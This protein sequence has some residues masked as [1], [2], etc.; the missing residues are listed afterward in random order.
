MAAAAESGLQA[1]LMAPTELL[2][3]QHY[4]SLRALLGDRT[5]VR[6]LTSSAAT[7]AIREETFE[8]AGVATVRRH[9]R[10]LAADRR[11]RPAG[12]RRGRRAAS[13]SAWRSAATAREGR[14]P[15]S[16][17]DDRDAD[18]ALA[19]ADG[20]RRSRRLGDRRAAARAPAGRQPGSQPA[21]EAGCGLSLAGDG[22]R[23]RAQGL[24]G[25]AADRGERQGGGRG[26][27]GARAGARASCSSTYGPTVLHGRME[28]AAKARHDGG[29]RRAA[30]RRSW[31]RPP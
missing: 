7:A 30:T 18:S 9:P 2:A 28:S 3:E 29:F 1:A 23:R 20:L 27:R 15:G 13:A 31:S 6:L 22:A 8:A 26:R 5:D 25:L 21:A 11:V 10:A 4:R 12:A 16:P 19:R 24:R 17:G 14:P